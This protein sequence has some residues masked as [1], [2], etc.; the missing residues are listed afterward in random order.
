MKKITKILLLLILLFNTHNVFAL[1]LDK[2]NL[3]IEAGKKEKVNLYADL[4]EDT[5]KVEFTL[6]FESYDIPVIFSP[7]E[8]VKD[9]TPDGPPHTLTLPEASSGKTLLGYVT[10][11]VV[12]TP[13]VVG[14]SANLFKA[15]AINSEGEKKQLTNQDLTVKIGK[16][17]TENTT[18]NTNTEPKVVDMNFLKSIQSD[19]VSISI[20]ENIFEYNVSV[21]SDLEELDLKP[22]PKDEKYTVSISSQKIKDLSDDKITITVSNGKEKQKY[23]VNVSIIKEAKKV[24]IDTSEF[25]SNNSYKTKWV[26]VLIGTSLALAGAI[27]LNKNK[28]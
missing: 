1:S 4:P 19:I 8:G 22:I 25:E 10:A 11:R 23:I 5:E 24:D 6:T 26:V 9:K 21:K 18:P 20:E 14:S 2:K 7:A 28:R 3:T 13:N 27:I 15:Y 17:V 16:E 12:A